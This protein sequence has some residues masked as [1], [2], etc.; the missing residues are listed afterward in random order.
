[1][2]NYSGNKHLNKDFSRGSD[3]GPR[4]WSIIDLFLLAIVYCVIIDSTD[5]I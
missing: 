5:N 4:Y 1:M 2:A 3:L